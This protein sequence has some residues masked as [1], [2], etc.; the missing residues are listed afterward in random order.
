MAIGSVGSSSAYTLGGKPLGVQLGGKSAT[1]VFGGGKSA[2][3]LIA[4]TSSATSASGVQVAPD[5]M[6]L[7]GIQDEIDRTLGYR[8]NLSVAEK[9]QLADLQSKI[10]GL[11][12]SAQTRSLTESELT[13]RGDY[14][15]EAYAILGKDYVDVAADSFLQAKTDELST[16][17]ATKPKGADAKRLE[18]L[19]I[20]RD[21]ITDRVSELG[22]SGAD[23]YYQQARSISA[24]IN[25]LTAPR[26]ITDL[27]REE[28][29]THDEIADA[30]NEHA[31][32]ELQITSDKRL[33][34]ARLQMT[35]EMIR[36]GG[37]DTLI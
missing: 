3:S 31:G 19:E 4:I 32:Q 10:G 16:L 23:I 25:K 30:I 9:Q 27:S 15:V 29:R 28:L 36:Q 8:T 7:K 26:S 35:M 34:I 21:R 12:E 13:E 20:M 24:Q 1:D 37:V 14:Y 2:D 18:R 11:N 33:K 5:Q 17:M 22:A 6:I